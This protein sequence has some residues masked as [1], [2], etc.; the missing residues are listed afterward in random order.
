MTAGFVVGGV[1]L[2]LF[3]W[4]AMFIPPR[5]GIWPR[6]WIAAIT[7]SGYSIG[8]LAVLGR[9][10]DVVGP[11]DLV[12]VGVGLGVG[13][14]WL[15]ATHVGHWVLARVFPSFVAQIRDLYAVAADD[16]FALVAPPVVAM[17]VTEELL[18]R[19]LVQGSAGLAVGVAAYTFVQIVERKWTLLLAAVLGGLVWGLLY[20]W[21][22]GLVAPVVA[23]VLWTG[24]LTFFWPLRAGGA[25]PEAD[26]AAV[27]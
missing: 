26:R 11:V 4:A 5:R 22:D 14:A 25:V 16:R 18:F 12:E 20:W 2:A 13:G 3:M 17:G 15:I 6:T 24:T 21:R 8:A 19:G 9:L 23:H 1:V 10:D 7:L 27:T